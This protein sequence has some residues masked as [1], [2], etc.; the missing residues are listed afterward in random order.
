MA[1]R[2]YKFQE[3]VAHAGD[4]NCLN[5]GKKSRRV[6]V[7]GGNDR[8]VNLWGFDSSNYLLSLSGH[9]TSVQSVTFDSAEVLVLAGASNG[10]IKLW[11]LEEGKSECY[12]IDVRS[13]TGHRSSCTSVEFHPFGEFFASGSMDTDLKIWDIRKKGSIH[14]Y[15]GHTRGIKTIKF[16]PDGRWVVT[17]GE[18]NIVKLWDLTAGK[19]LHDFKFHKGMI[20]CIDF[21]PH[22]FLLAT[23]SADRTVK[24]WDLETFELIGSSGPEA[25]GISSMIFH[26][27][28]KTLFCAL[29]EVL[30]VLSWEPI[31]CHDAVQMGWSSL[32]DLTIYEGKLLGCSYQQSRVG[33]WIADISLIGPYAIGLGLNKNSL[34]EP[35]SSHMENSS[36]GLTGSGTKCNSPLVT[37]ALGYAVKPK[38]E[39]GSLPV[40]S[41]EC[42]QSPPKE[43]DSIYS[44]R[45]SLTSNGLK[46]RTSAVSQIAKKKLDSQ[47]LSSTLNSTPFRAAKVAE[48]SARIPKRSV[49]IVSSRD[50]SPS[51]K[52]SILPNGHIMELHAVKK[53][54]E[55]SI[56]VIVP[57]NHVHRETTDG[58]RA[59]N[60][61][62]DSLACDVIFGSPSHVGKSS[63][64]SG[65]QSQSV[66]MSFGSSGSISSDVRR[67]N[68]S[69]KSS[70]VGTD[71]TPAAGDGNCSS[72]RYVAEK[73]ERSMSLEQPGT[74]Q[75]DQSEESVC[76]SNDHCS[77]K[78][79]RG[80]AVQL[81]KT[82]SLVERFERRESFGHSATAGSSFE[83]VIIFE[84]GYKGPVLDSVRNKQYDD[85]NLICNLLSQNHDVFINSLKSRLT[86]L[87]AVRHFWEYN[88]IKAAVDAVVKL[89]D[90]SVQVD[91]VSVLRG[92]ID[93]FTLDL[94]CCLLPLLHGLVN[95]KTERHIIVSLEM[96]LELV[97]VFGPLV[98]STISAASFVGVDLHAE[99]RFQRSKQCHHH[100][101]RINQILPSVIKHLSRSLWFP[102]LASCLCCGMHF[103]A[104]IRE[105][106]S[107]DVWSSFLQFNAKY[108][109]DY[110]FVWDS[111]H[112]TS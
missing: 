46:S 9:T 106:D 78:Y 48:T 39:L 67:G 13:V 18:D 33:V 25:T 95:S 15:K 59:V 45:V 22:E 105:C 29:D 107:Q 66:G 44:A 99:E 111:F 104:S 36:I 80:V 74:V 70:Q 86:K 34:M 31:I 98:W 3:F 56:P 94:F 58:P 8:V 49:S 71:E 23:G 37:G 42:S 11:D 6:F 32:A 41:N 73:F 55:L 88:G 14:T 97:K 110:G 16:T 20:S 47:F 27:D 68:Y 54:Q 52:S 89:P 21:H 112:T 87:E 108:F 100:L 28:G 102:H 90:H 38:G 24:F 76:S 19:L 60:S 69:S 79:V 75:T 62:A 4:V 26:P 61:D 40:G 82:R 35:I 96:L 7:T 2:G 43:T 63:C 12:A 1:K 77:V 64:E 109:F 30:K 17:G 72:I 93:L 85:D 65:C 84:Y 53:P 10:T 101:E 57:R 103:V 92:K 5:I 81:G 91:L 50:T 51:T 83:T